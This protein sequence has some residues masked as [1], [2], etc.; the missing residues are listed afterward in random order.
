MVCALRKTMKAY[1]NNLYQFKVYLLMQRITC[2]ITIMKYVNALKLI[3]AQ[4]F[5]VYGKPDAPKEIIKV[6]G[7]GNKVVVNNPGGTLSAKVVDQY[8]NPISNA[9]LS[10][11]VEPAVSLNPAVPL[12]EG[13]RNLTLGRS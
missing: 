1:I 4:P 5:E 8:G 6:L 10:F 13:Y 12:P 2:L 7:D 11:G 3:I 9:I